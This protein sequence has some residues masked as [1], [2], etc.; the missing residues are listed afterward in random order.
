MTTI[1]R[2]TSTAALTL[3]RLYFIRFGFA[4]VW[5]IAL[6]VSGPDL[7]GVSITLL[8]L[9]PAFDLAA[10]VWDFRTSRGIRR[11]PALY[12]NMALSLVTALGLA[13]A[14]TSGVSAVFVVWGAWAVATGAV[15]LIVA[16]TRRRLGG[17]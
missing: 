11:T 10:A 14:A 9:Y 3:R 17:Q 4:I 13:I 7:T 8:V 15:Q 16:V 2:E 12:V 1:D 5:A 6:A